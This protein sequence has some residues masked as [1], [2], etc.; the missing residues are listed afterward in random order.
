MNTEEAN[1]HFHEISYS[2]EE[3]FVI[4]YNINFRT[5]SFYYHLKNMHFRSCDIHTDSSCHR[6]AKADQ[7]QDRFSLISLVPFPGEKLKKEKKKKVFEAFVKL[8]N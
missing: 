2:S 1:T 7:S 5:S 8:G 6:L 3:E 4:K